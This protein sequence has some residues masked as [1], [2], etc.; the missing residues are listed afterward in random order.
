MFVSIAMQRTAALRTHHMEWHSPS[1]KEHGIRNTWR[2]VDSSAISG[3]QEYSTS[4][5]SLQTFPG[6]SDQ[7]LQIFKQCGGG[8]GG[9]VPLLTA[10]RPTAYAVPTSIRK[11]RNQGCALTCRR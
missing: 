3:F 7:V 4:F 2:D 9:A 1:E 11:R 8:G 6:T 10:G 5:I